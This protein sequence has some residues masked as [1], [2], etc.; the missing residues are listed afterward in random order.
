MCMMNEEE[1]N[2]R[3]AEKWEGAE[4]MKKESVVKA[5]LLGLGT[6]GSGVYKLVERQKEQ[7]PAKTGMQLEIAKILVHDMKKE[8]PGV[9]RELLTDSFEEILKDSD[10]QIVIEVVG[11][12]EPAKRMIMDALKA[13]KNVVTANKD[14]IAAHGRELLN[15][16]EEHHVD[17]LFEASVAGGI[18][19]INP[20][21]ECLAGNEILSVMGI[22]NG[23]TNYILTKMTEEG[24]DF[25]EALKR[26]Q[27]LGY[28]EADP[29]SDIEGHDAGRKVAIL[30]S[31]AFHSKVTF[32]DVYVEGITRIT[33][34]DIAYAEEFGNVIKLLGIAR[35]E[36]GEIEAAV[37]PMMLPKDHPLAS[38]RDSFNAVFVQGDAVGDT[39]FYGRGAGELPTASAVMA[40]VLRILRN[41]RCGCNGRI[42]CTCYR[43]L[44]M[45][46]IEESQH[47]YYVR[48]L[49]ENRPG[50][51]AQITGTLAEQGVSIEKVVQKVFRDNK[52]EVVII[53]EKIQERYVKNALD[54]FRRSPVIYDISNILREY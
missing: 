34:R 46:P 42:G 37:Y 18:P 12:I 23:T 4:A 52:A 36:G 38:V 27:E 20:L 11:G 7:L 33:S 50:V 9:R 1:K 10:I 16:A 8:R 53:T 6:V 31:I 39:M 22:V 28:A 19:I 13:G 35:N 49:V 14:L 21:K 5:A 54:E 32:K 26:A 45:K 15:T 48:M 40:D 30:A 29:T 41:I 2:R 3:A 44:P 24:M 17:L 43:N 25:D 47:K 51:L